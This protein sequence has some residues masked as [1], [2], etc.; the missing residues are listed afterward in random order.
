MLILDFLMNLIRYMKQ[1]LVLLISTLFFVSC[2]QDA[3]EVVP[4]GTPVKVS[5]SISLADVQ[6]PEI[7]VNSGSS[8]TEPKS[9]KTNKAKSVAYSKSVSEAFLNSSGTNALPFQVNYTA[10]AKSIKLRSATTLSNVWVLQFDSTKTA[11]AASAGNCVAAQYIGT[12]TSETTIINPTLISG[13]GQV[14]YVLANGPASGGINT[15]T[16]TLSTF[17]TADFSGTITDDAS[18]PYLGR[19]PG[20][21]SITAI[22]ISG[23]SS[24]PLYRI[25]AKVSLTFKFA[26]T[27]YTLSSVEMYNKPIF[28]YYVNGSDVAVFPITPTVSDVNTSG[29]TANVVPGTP[30]NGTYV[31]YTGENKRGVNAAITSVYNKDASN[32]PSGSTYCTY[33]RI[34]ATKTGDPSTYYYYDLYVGSNNT[35]DFN[36]KRNWDYSI[37]VVIGGNEI[38]Q[39]L[40]DGVDGR[41]S[42][43][44]PTANSYIVAPNSSITI[45]V[46]IRGNGDLASA[47]IGNSFTSVSIAPLSVGLFWQTSTSPSVI[48]S[49]GSISNG[50]VTINTGSTSG[51]AVIAAYTN[52]N[53]TGTILWSWHI[54]VTDYNPA[55]SAITYTNG[56]GTQFTIMDRN[57][58]AMGTSYVEDNN[59]LH[60]QH[61]RKDPF[62]ALDVYDASGLTKSVVIGTSMLTIPV[63]VNNPYTFVKAISSWCSVSGSPSTYLWMGVNGTTTTPANKTIYDPCPTGWRVPARFLDQSPWYGYTS[64]T[65]DPTGKFMTITFPGGQSVSFPAAGHRLHNSTSLVFTDGGTIG[66]Y[67]SASTASAYQAPSMTIDISS[68][69]ITESSRYRAFGASV[70]CVQEW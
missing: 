1:I 45:P 11:G 62:S 55:S 17:K 37:N 30:T 43:I 5:L 21:V 13:T 48:S 23:I 34:K 18:V 61:G 3:T 16:Y 19:A 49:I 6:Y 66:D 68:N 39:D 26:V 63:S 9:S 10:P 58:G 27:G 56:G 47:Q 7:A 57:L 24:V 59:I 14:V 65:C 29:V 67:W 70:R 60:Y 25:A 33:I 41:I 2:V 35:T 8:S 53:N 44:I 52:A 46:N 50:R 64:S 54:W 36:V 31:W 28:M 51:N 4:E 22:G 40:Y 38:I 32:T 42:K 20:G 69:L 12:V 15:G